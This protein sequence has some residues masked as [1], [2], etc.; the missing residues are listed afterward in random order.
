[1]IKDYLGALTAGRTGEST[2]FTNSQGVLALGG[3]N[4][5]LGTT[6]INSGTILLQSNSALPATTAVTISTSNG[7]TLDLGG[8][9]AT[10]VGLL[11]NVVGSAATGGTVTNSGAANAT[12]SLA[13]ANGVNTTF[14]GVIRNGASK[15]I[16]LAVSGNGE[17]FLSAANTYTGGTTISGGTLAYGVANALPTTSSVTVNGGALSMGSFNGSVGAVTL[18]S[19]ALVGT[20]GVVTGTSYNVQ[21]GSIGAI[22]G[23]NGIAL[24]QT[25]AGIVSLSAANTYSGPTN[26]SGGTLQLAAGGSINN[27]PLINMANGATL[28]VSLEPSSSYTLASGQT[29]TGTGGFTVNG[30]LAAGPGATVLTTSSNLIRTLNA[31]GLTLNNGSLVN[32]DLTTSGSGDLINVTANNG[33]TIN[34]GSIGLYQVNGI[35]P[36]VDQGT[37]TLMN[38]QGTLQGAGTFST[39][40]NPVPGLNSYMFNANSGTLTVTIG[41]GNYWNGADV[42]NSNSNWSDGSNWSLSV[43]PSNGQGLAFTGATGLSNNNIVNLNAASISFDSTTGPYI[44]SGNSI[45]LSGPISNGGASTQTINM[46][47]GLLGTQ[48][49]NTAAGNVIFNGAISDSG[50]GYGLTVNAGSAAVS[51][52]AANTYSGNTSVTSG[53]L[54]LLH[55]LAVQNSTVVPVGT[56]R[57]VFDQS[58]GGAFTF[59]GLGGTAPI[60]L[61]DNGGNPVA[62]TVGNN[63][64]S[65]AYSGVL[66]GSGSLIKVDTGTQTLSGASTFNGGVTING[67]AISVNSLSA[68]GTNASALGEGPSNASGQSITLNGGMLTYTGAAAAGNANT[69]NNNALGFNPIITLLGGGGTL[70]DTGGGISFSGGL[71]GSGN[72]TILNTA[73]TNQVF[74]S[75]ATPNASSGY[76]GNITIGSGGRVQLRSG[77]A[78]LFGNAASVTINAGG[79]LQADSNTGAGGTPPSSLANNLVMNGGT[80]QLQNPGLM[81][82]SGSV[83]INSPFNSAFWASGTTSQINLSGNLLGSGSAT[84]VGNPVVMLGGNNGSFMGA[85]I[86]T[87]TA[88][89]MFTNAAAGSTNAVWATNGGAYSANIAGGGTVDMGA[90][91][92]TT[93]TVSNIFAG[94]TTTIS[95]GAGDQHD[96]WRTD[97]QWWRQ[98]HY[99]PQ[100]GGCGEPGTHRCLQL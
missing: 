1:M 74:F 53:T 47:I 70:N 87:G 93:G 2:N 50:S 37:Y 89:T 86:A 71:T 24:T 57:I 77:A 79:F 20:T 44:L 97:Y 52:A 61:T 55:S 21:S 46:N 6:A 13:L 22:L 25:T 38:Y 27:S 19:G 16:A 45:Q 9:S 65:T 59:G 69:G 76:T 49:I 29:L 68:G 15:T 81:T 60:A 92:G 23:G 39:I 82:F 99:G 4:S 18:S 26:I 88:G 36:I 91:T 78:N 94:T 42:I 7:S 56:A 12:L 95:V 34:G 83:T 35:V 5:Y 100:Q 72:L 32:M 28:D 31:G 75:T 30:T 63:N 66:S 62:L 48:T 11:S 58:V 40:A 73:G 84:E 41:G 3:T 8:N 43:S 80:L 54:A 67:G 10:I 90:L 96:L 14:R 33:L 64:A 51:L 85:W 98:C 17:Q